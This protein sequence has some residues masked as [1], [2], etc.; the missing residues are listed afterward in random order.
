MVIL[1]FFRRVKKILV[2]N[3]TK[4]IRKLYNIN[5]G[6]IIQHNIPIMVKTFYTILCRLNP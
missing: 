1:H 5:T 6:F 2:L 4:N 3:F